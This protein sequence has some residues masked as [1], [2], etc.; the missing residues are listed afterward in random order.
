MAKKYVV[1]LTPEEREHLRQ[2]I[3]SGTERARKLTHAR[4][5]LKADAGWRDAE[6]ST[7]LEVSI[8]TIERVRRRFVKEGLE[9]ALNRRPLRREY[10]YKGHL[11]NCEHKCSTYA[12][13][14]TTA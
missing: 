8:L 6:I 1:T 7:A 12:T 9:A 14:G 13:R 2:M 5:L 3:A 4:I 10:L 11:P